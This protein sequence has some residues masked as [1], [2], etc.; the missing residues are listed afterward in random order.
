MASS[1]ES[2]S[3]KFFD[4]PAAASSKSLTRRRRL[5]PDHADQLCRSIREG[6]FGS[7]TNFL[8]PFG[9]LPLTYCDYIASGRSLKFIEDF[10]S[11][12]VLPFYGNTH[13]VTTVTSLQTTLL[14]A[15]ARDIVR[16]SVN[17]AE[18]DAVIFTGNFA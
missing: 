2:K 11:T 8:G 9:R 13:T 12:Q 16:N 4:L 15:E 1:S 7:D 10:L 3:R 14:R 18:Q 6:L 5:D 17:A